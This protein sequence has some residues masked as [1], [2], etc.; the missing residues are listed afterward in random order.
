MSINRTDG[1]DE[2]STWGKVKRW[3]SHNPLT[4]RLLWFGLGVLLVAGLVW[5]VYPQPQTRFGGGGRGGAQ[6]PSRSASPPPIAATST[7][8]S[9][10][11]AP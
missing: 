6:T 1:T 10:R 7:S 2:L 11:L 9:M 5:L 4:A 8:P 3:S